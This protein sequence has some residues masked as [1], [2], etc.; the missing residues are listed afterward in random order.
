MDIHVHG[1]PHVL[2]CFFLTA[3]DKGVSKMS[4]TETLHCNMDEYKCVKVKE[5]TGPGPIYI[6]RLEQTT[7][8]T[9]K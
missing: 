6:K 8:K 1:Q 2:S 5:A 9:G 7:H 3:T 4:H